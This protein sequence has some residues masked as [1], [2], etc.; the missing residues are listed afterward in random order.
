MNI[1][2]ELSVANKTRMYGEQISDLNLIEKILCS[3]I[4]RY[5]Y[6]VCSIKESHDLDTLTTVDELKSSLLVHE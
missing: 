2:L 5:D 3:I 4:S 6:V 1:L